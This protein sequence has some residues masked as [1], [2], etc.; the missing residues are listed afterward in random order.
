MGYVPLDPLMDYVWK[1]ALLLAVL[2]WYIWAKHIAPHRH[3]S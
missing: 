1:A 3:H 2:G